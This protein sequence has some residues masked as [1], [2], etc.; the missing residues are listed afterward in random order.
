MGWLFATSYGSGVVPDVDVR[1]L[2][3]LFRRG[4]V[5]QDTD[6]HPV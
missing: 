2:Q 6:G 5:L 3:D 4:G 1:F